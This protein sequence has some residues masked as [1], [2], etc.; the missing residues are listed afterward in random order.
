MPRNE[1]K[2][3]GYGLLNLSTGYDWRNLSV[4][5]GIDNA[6]D[7]QYAL[8]LG[9]A[10]MGQGRTMS[11]NSELGTG[12]SNWGTPVYGAGRSYFISLNHKFFVVNK[13]TI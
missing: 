8:P 12:I 13:K 7:K 10:Y 9:G 1:I 11:M 4:T 3:A 5:V 2:T 6:L